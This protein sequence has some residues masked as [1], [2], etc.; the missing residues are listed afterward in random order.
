MNNGEIA[1]LIMIGVE[2]LLI[3]HLHGKQKKEKHNFWI[4]LLSVSIWILL[5]KWAGL[6]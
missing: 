4:T 1:I 2:L 5:L 6:F 3:A